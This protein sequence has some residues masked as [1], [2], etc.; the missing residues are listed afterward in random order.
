MSIYDA[1]GGAT[2]VAAAVDLFYEKVLADPALAPWFADSAVEDL[3]RHQRAFF[4]MAL[5]G[6]QEYGGR[7][8]ADAHEGRAITGQA[9]ALVAG[10]LAST[11]LELGVDQATVDTIITTV[12]TLRNDIVEVQEPAA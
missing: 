7:S 5:G 2:S 6:P 10:H 1:I 8:M 4:N 12:A 11:L 9:F 3:K